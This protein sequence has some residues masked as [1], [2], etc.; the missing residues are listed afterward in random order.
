M[1]DQ[2]MHFLG[3]KHR[4]SNANT[5]SWIEERGV[6]AGLLEFLFVCFLLGQDYLRLGLDALY[7]FT[8]MHHDI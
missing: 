2:H 6:N 3:M 1:F 7:I 4:F 8:N 5:E